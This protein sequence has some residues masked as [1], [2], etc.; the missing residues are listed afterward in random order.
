MKEI[1]FKFLRKRLFYVS[2]QK[3]RLEA[4]NVLPRP[5]L[6]VLMHRLGL[7]IMTSYVQ[8]YHYS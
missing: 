6:D 2:R 4:A 8:V 7:N 5:S 1:G 3:P